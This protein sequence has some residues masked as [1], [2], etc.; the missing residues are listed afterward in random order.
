MVNAAPKEKRSLNPRYDELLDEL[1]MKPIN[2][3]NDKEFESEF[4]EKHV[5]DEENDN[6]YDAKNIVT[7][8]MMK[9][10]DEEALP[11]VLELIF[12]RKVTQK[13]AD[14]DDEL[15]DEFWMKPINVV[16]DKEFESE[17]KE[18]HVMDEENDNI[19]DTKNIVTKK[20]MKGLQQQEDSNLFILGG[21]DAARG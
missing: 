4:E 8:K 14:I 17:F 2:V 18:K 16:N 5:M 6:I 3:V 9:E 12:R 1:W 11:D 15:L 20:M 19:Y 10:K 21:G 13:H 7:K